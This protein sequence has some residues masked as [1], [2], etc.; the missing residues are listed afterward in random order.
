M[1]GD[2]FRWISS[3]RE[4]PKWRKWGRDVGE[5]RREEMRWENVNVTAVSIRHFCSDVWFV[6]TTHAESKFD[7]I[8]TLMQIKHVEPASFTWEQH[9]TGIRR[10][11]SDMILK[12]FLALLQLICTVNNV[13]RR[14]IRIL[15]SGSVSGPGAKRR[16]FTNYCS[17]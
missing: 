9:S 11:T 5:G 1:C 16:L 8:V 6:S 2:V 14:L 13:S 10:Q 12:R 7:P 17:S 3:V 15:I 4:E